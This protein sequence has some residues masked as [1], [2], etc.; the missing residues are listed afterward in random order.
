M[1]VEENGYIIMKKD[2]LNFYD[3][4]CEFSETLDDA[5]V[6]TEMSYAKAD[7][8]GLV[9]EYGNNFEIVHYNKTIWIDKVG[10]NT[11]KTILEF[12][13]ESEDT[14]NE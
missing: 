9:E 14:N 10:L 13:D 4:N 8:D 12:V 3:N 7:Y 11:E 5:K 2:E 6:Y 1:Y